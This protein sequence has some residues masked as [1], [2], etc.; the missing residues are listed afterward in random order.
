MNRKCARLSVICIALLIAPNLASSADYVSLLQNKR[1][2]MKGAK[3]AGLEFKGD[4]TVIGYAEMTGNVPIYEARI[5]WVRDDLFMVV[6]KGRVAEKC[7]PRTWLYEIIKLSGMTIIIKEYW[8][9]W[10]VAPDE[11]TEYRITPYP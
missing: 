4:K 2:I 7:P 6:E 3:S 9:G 10:P 1:L 11:T 8:T 5:K